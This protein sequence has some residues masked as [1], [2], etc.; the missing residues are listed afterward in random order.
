MAPEPD[1]RSITLLVVRFDYP[2]LG[3]HTSISVT[4]DI[5]SSVLPGMQREAVDRLAALIGR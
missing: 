5:H 2:C 3:G 4:M 1:N